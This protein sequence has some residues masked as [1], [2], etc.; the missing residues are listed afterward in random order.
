[1]ARLKL[2]R[3][4]VKPPAPEVLAHYVRVYDPRELYHHPDSVLP[5][6]SESL[7]GN[8]HPL[9]LD[10]GCG[11]GEFLVAQAEDHRDLNFLGFDWHVKS[12]W[13]ATQAAHQAEL[14]NVRL[15]QV[16][17]RLALP[18]MPAGSAC[19]VFMLFPQP[20]FQHNRTSEDPLLESTL[21]QV[22]RVLAP[23][24]WFHFVTD[25]AEYFEIKRA[26]I[27]QSGLF[28]VS[29]ESQAYEGGITWF[30]RFWETR[31]IESR[32]LACRKV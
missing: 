14:D 10:L 7:F 13:A 6:T 27:E 3:F 23:E 17:F 19:E 8:D 15:I 31:Q 16:D 29:N 30:Q 20:V 11:R 2:K 21:R 9:V 26:L 32:R 24:G 22:Q 28:T 25:H 12:L 18:A 5:I 1:M 4:R